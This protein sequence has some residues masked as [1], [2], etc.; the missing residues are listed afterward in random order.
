MQIRSPVRGSGALMLLAAVVAGLLTYALFARAA[1]Q[2][3]AAEPASVGVSTGIFSEEQAEIGSMVFARRCAGCHGGQLG[4]GMGPRLA[5]LAAFWQGRSLAELFS[6]VRG[7]MP[8]DAPGS[9]SSEE[10]AQVIA[11]VLHSNGY[12]A[13]AEEMPADAAELQMF[14]FDE[15]PTE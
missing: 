14:V 5:P 10:Y 9:L 12:P 1:A 13:G 4:G 8:F 6:F 7:N 3:Q 2:G 11:F 15:P